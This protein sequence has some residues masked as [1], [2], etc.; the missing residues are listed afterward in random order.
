M[1]LVIFLAIFGVLLLV[2]IIFVVVIIVRK[3]REDQRRVHD[4]AQNP[5]QGQVFVRSHLLKL[6]PNEVEHLFPVIIRGDIIPDLQSMSNMDKT[7]EDK[8]EYECSICLSEIEADDPIRVGYCRHIFHANCLIQWFQ[9]Q[10]RCPYCRQDFGKRATFTLY[11]ELAKEVGKK[12]T[13]VELVKAIMRP[14][15]NQTLET[16]KV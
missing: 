13:K 10:Q 12:V 1:V 6:S 15:F 2:G 8:P 9:K 5:N 11:K 3:W 7:E 4:N 14:R 16:L